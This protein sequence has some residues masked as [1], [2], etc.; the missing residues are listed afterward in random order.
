ML[1]T[2]LL[3]P[4]LFHRMMAKKLIYWDKNYA[5]DGERKL[6]DAQNKK[7]GIPILQNYS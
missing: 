3:F 4:Y 7:S 1:Y 6:A 2:A 5:S